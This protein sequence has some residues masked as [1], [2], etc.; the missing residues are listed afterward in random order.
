MVVGGD[1]NGPDITSAVDDRILR[2][3]RILRKFKIDELPQ[4]WNVLKGD[5]SLVGSRPEV[6]QYVEFFSQDF[7]E[8]LVLRPGITDEAS[9]IYFNEEQLLAGTKNPEGRYR[10]QILPNKIRIYLDYVHSFSMAKDFSILFKT[11]LKLLRLN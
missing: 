4:L 10:E 8:I 5:M 2:S 9:L 7:D 11:L 3:G 6:R 1:R